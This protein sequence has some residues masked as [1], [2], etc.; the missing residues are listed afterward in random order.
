MAFGPVGLRIIIMKPCIVYKCID[1]TF[2]NIIYSASH[3][4]YV[5]IA[6]IATIIISYYT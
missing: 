4:I 2:D 1:I 5:H 6:T 3:I